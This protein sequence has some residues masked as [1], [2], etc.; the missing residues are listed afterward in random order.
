MTSQYGY[1]G[2][3]LKV[4]LSSQSVITLPTS[5]YADGFLGGRGIATKFYW[6]EVPP[7]INA[8]DPQN[9]LVFVTGPSAGFKGLSGSRWQVCGKA[10]AMVPEHFSYANLG[11][12]WGAQL[13][14]AG[15]D[16]IVVSGK[17]DKPV[18]IFVQNGVAEIR[19]ASVLWGKSTIETREVLKREL[20]NTVAVVACGP[21]GENLVSYA[22]LLADNDAS[23]SS[24]FGAVMGSKKL[25][26]IA[27]R[28][29]GK[30]V[31]SD[32]DKLADLTRYVQKLSNKYIPRNIT[33]GFA[34]L[35]A[36]GGQGE[37]IPQDIAELHFEVLPGQRVMR[38]L[39]FGCI[40]N[41]ERIIVESKDGKTRG[42]SYCASALFYINRS[43]KYHGEL[44]EVPFYASRLC[45]AYGIDSLSIM[46]MIMWLSRCSHAG[47]LNDENT[48][49]PL[50]RLGSWEYIETLVKKISLRQGFGDVLAQGM[51]KAAHIVGGGAP[52]LI[53]DFKSKA[54]HHLTFC[55]RMFPVHG[56][57]YAMEP[58]QPIHQLHEMATTLFAWLS[59]AG[60]ADGAYLSSDVFSRIAQQFWGSELAADFSTYAGKALAAIRIQD[61][62]YAKESLILCDFAWPI[63]HTFS[64]N[65]VGDP[66]LESRILSA[67]IGADVDESS[68]NKMG[69]KIFNLQRA[70]LIR[71]GHSGRNDDRIP[72]AF[73]SMPLKGD[74]V[75]PD[76]KVPGKNG[77]IISRKGAV[78]DRND[79]EMMKDE[80]YGLRGWDVATGLQTSA[81]LRELGLNEVADDL[82]QAGLAI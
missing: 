6:D 20:G 70:I 47:I 22:T 41:G 69:E 5:D 8:F 19:D 21:A 23:G 34:E 48:G 61:R 14:F 42:K 82:A 43:V 29:N 49:I 35:K 64:N 18:Y 36:A 59:W 1:A 53:T 67:V 63:L 57:L 52:E 78:V 13:K 9:V 12:R 74:E 51:E 15:Y 16:A 33:S 31:A 11:G 54:G 55:P 56:L 72:E 37:N 30:V 76:C 79:F 60:G 44:N 10:P 71:E 80:Y 62:A 32:P 26:A 17:S 39:C 38:D 50:S 68:L 75:N 2:K 77:E 58:R 3:I 46:T 66:T 81:K 24:G 40:G 4:D 65:H 25:K 28:G 7:N 73:Y 27:V 45:D